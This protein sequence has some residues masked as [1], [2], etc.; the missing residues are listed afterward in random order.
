MSATRKRAARR[1]RTKPADMTVVGVN[2]LSW[3]E[4]LDIV[5]ALLEVLDGVYSHL[6]LKRSL[7]G[8]DVV[9]ALEHL[10]QALPT[11]TDIEFHRQLTSLVNHLRDAHTQY[12]GPWTVKD[13]VASLP[14][15]VEAFGPADR[16]TYV[17]SKIDRK[18]VVDPHFV[19]GVTIEYWNGIPLDRA[20]D[21]H[22]ENETG[23]RPDAR[24]A[25]ALESL[26]FRSLEYAPPPDE[27]W[28]VLG[29]RDVKGKTREVRL[30]WEGFDVGRAPTASHTLGT[31]IRRGIN[32]AAEAV[33][34]AKK[35]RFNRALYNAERKATPGRKARG[36][37]PA[38]ADFLSSDIR[39]TKSGRFGY[40][41]IWSFDVDDDQAFLDAA[42]AHLRRLPDRGLIIDLRD[43]P[44]GFIW[45]AERM[46]QLFTPNRVTPTKFALR[47]THLT[48][49]MAQAAFNQ[50]ELAAWA[51]SLLTAEQTGEPYSSHLPI[52]PPDICND[53]GQHYSGPVVVVVDANTYSSGDLFTAGI[54]DNGIG[55]VVCI[56]QA[57]GA[58]GANVWSS[59]DLRA[60]LAAAKSPLPKLIEG[61]GFTVAI[62]RAVR[63]GSADGTLIED[64]GVSGQPYEM[65][66]DDIF[67]GNR[68]LIEHCGELLAAM[69]RTRMNVRRRGRALTVET[70]GLDQLDL[71]VGGHPAGV[72]IAL[73]R[74][75]TR[76]VR[77]PADA[78]DVEVVGFSDG[79][80]L[81]RR[82]IA[83]A[84]HS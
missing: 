46:L 31:R 4:R 45:A 66:H 28:V 71:Y 44:G 52:T 21:L 56:G 19:K 75:G 10:R 77:L 50:S 48:S 29:Y 69:P 58:G 84:D 40:L 11:M 38:F 60:A 25:R 1:A 53:I 64:A 8:F 37:A 76:R 83:T 51:E 23:G 33:R 3:A 22:A 73:T 47:A 5:D 7:Y 32:D 41:R 27:E 42:I 61:V 24:R 17:V 14:F 2:P 43:N 57:T 72:P 59:D 20:V 74:D 81:Q 13:A 34:R 35:Y 26:T 12:Q 79:V 49:A 9:R 82:R 80:V 67:K 16:P 55:P 65:T 63:S 62:R 15:L 18:S 70:V 68:D 36:V 30:D 6:T 54:V 78:T 39:T